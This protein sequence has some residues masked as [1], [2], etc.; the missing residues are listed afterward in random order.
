MVLLYPSANLLCY[1]PF[2][3]VFSKAVASLNHIARAFT[4]DLTYEV[5]VDWSA[6][7]RTRWGHDPYTQGAYSFLPVGCLPSDHDTLIEPLRAHFGCTGD[8]PC[9]T[10]ARKRAV[11]GSGGGGGDSGGESDATGSPRS[12]GMSCGIPVVHFAGEAT[13]PEY[14][15]SIHAA[16]LSGE[17]VGREVKEALERMQAW[18]T[19][20]HG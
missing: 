3:P 16:L 4:K 1:M 5:E 14:M 19:R 15:G 9:V 10:D 8:A 18:D 11:S 13:D 6:A 12:G 17:R 7:V 2:D 20:P